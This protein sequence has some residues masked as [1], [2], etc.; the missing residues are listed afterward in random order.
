MATGGHHVVLK[1]EIKIKAEK[2]T[3][4]LAG[5]DDGNEEDQQ[6]QQSRT[7]K[8]QQKRPSVAKP[9]PGLDEFIRKSVERIVVTRGPNEVILQTSFEHPCSRDMCSPMS[10]R[11]LIEQKRLPADT[12]IIHP[13]VYVCCFGK[14]HVCTQVSV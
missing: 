10:E 8:R 9:E 7:K 3:I 4:M 13:A 5:S 14:V 2:D 12:T 1:G 6:Q 11:D